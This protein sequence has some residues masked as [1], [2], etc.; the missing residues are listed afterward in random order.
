MRTIKAA[1]CCS[2]AT[3]EEKSSLEKGLMVAGAAAAREE[4]DVPAWQPPCRA[5]G[6]SKAPPALVGPVQPSAQL[7]VLLEVML[8]LQIGLVLW[9]KS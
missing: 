1:G 7:A 8:C 2:T 9:P 6:S 4:Q 5:A 3:P